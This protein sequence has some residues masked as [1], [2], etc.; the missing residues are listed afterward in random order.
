MEIE[1]KFFH[2]N[3]YE[4]GNTISFQPFRCLFSRHMEKIEEIVTK[5]TKKS[6]ATQAV[7]F[8]SWKININFP[9]YHT[10]L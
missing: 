8:Y 7:K 6:M 5:I 4:Y 1:S 10:I 2:T 9:D 3:K